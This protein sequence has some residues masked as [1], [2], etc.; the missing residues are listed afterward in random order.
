M[1]KIH[2]IIGD[3]EY[4]TLKAHMRLRQKSL[5]SGNIGG[6]VDDLVIKLI[7]AI[8]NEQHELTIQDKTRTRPA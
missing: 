7:R 5:L 2:L 3:Q 8:G 1:K 6:A 4:N